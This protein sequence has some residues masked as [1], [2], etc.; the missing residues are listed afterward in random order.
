[1]A[2]S[3]LRTPIP[4]LAFRTQTWEESD[5]LRHNLLLAA[6]CDIYDGRS[7]YT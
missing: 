3:P 4:I 1:M 5:T 6:L 7:A 2:G